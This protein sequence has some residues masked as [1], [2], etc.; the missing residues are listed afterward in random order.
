MNGLIDDHPPLIQVFSTCNDKKYLMN[1][2]QKSTSVRKWSTYVSTKTY[3]SSTDFSI[4]NPFYVCN[5]NHCRERWII[6]PASAFSQL[7]VETIMIEFISTWL[8]CILA[9]LF[10]YFAILNRNPH[11]HRCGSSCRCPEIY[12]CWNWYGSDLQTL[13]EQVQWV[14]K[15]FHDLDPR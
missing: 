4:S 14:L 2:F 1:T 15:K 8:K 13:E 11:T 5:L 9:R 6:I 10:K 12:H 3:H 7:K